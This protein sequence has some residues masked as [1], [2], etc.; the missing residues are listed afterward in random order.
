MGL[1]IYLDTIWVNVRLGKGGLDP[2]PSGSYPPVH[3]ISSLGQTLANLFLK[4]QIINISG[5]V[6]QEAKSRPLYSYLYNRKQIS[7]H[8]LF[9]KLKTYL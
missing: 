1:Q 2:I 5:F 6:D 8:I 4:V 3:Q 7:T 9:M